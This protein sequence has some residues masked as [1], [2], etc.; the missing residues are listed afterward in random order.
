V[1]DD[2]TDLY[3]TSYRRLV[4]QVY[5]FTTDL[6]EA[7]DA[8][9]EAFAR[10][11]ARRG[12]LSDIDAPEAWLRTVAV[13]IVKRRW[14]RKQLLDRILLR[15]RPV[16]RFLEDAPQPD[17]AD[18]RDALATIPRTYRE[19]IV[20]HYLADLPVDE[21][22]AI[23]E[24]PVGTVKSRL[25]RGREAL[26]GLLDDVEAPPLSQ[27]ERRAGQIKTRRRVAQAAA[28]LVGLT[29]SGLAL[30]PLR[31]Q[32]PVDPA[33]P[34]TAPPPPPSVLSWAGAGL[35]LRSLPEFGTLPDLDGKIDAY[36]IDGQDI[37][38]TD[39]GVY[40]RSHDGGQTWEIIDYS[41]HAGGPW[42]GLY[43][44]DFE[45]TWVAPRRSPE[46][47]WWMGGRKDGKPA[48]AHSPDGREWHYIEL[49]GGDS[50]TATLSGND[51]FALVL[52]G[53]KVVRAYQGNLSGGMKLLS[54]SSGGVAVS[55]EPIVLPDGRI[56][57]ADGKDWRLSSDQ[58]RTWSG[59]TALPVTV[60]SLRQT[61][62][63]YV[64]LGLFEVGWVATST[65][66]V[67]WQKLPIR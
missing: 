14:R 18:L 60:G 64:A 7:Q 32:P 1:R 8:V 51:V 45:S 9:Q 55:G 2:M 12:H 19:V 17:R 66:G 54:E 58:G 33:A 31:I 13:N 36:K 61:T 47:Q 43:P 24:V 21:V 48:L 62:D 39:A 49:E 4:A 34:T 44:A 35:I 37:L 5:A 57:V 16:T 29:L 10:A 26:K 42:G 15:E 41:R 52:D 20:L 50:V 22:A 56:L 6:G 28:A 3:H 65:D 59:G 38:H 11:L 53:S 67:S 30:L 25:S 63:G 23:L 40:A 46:G 27:V